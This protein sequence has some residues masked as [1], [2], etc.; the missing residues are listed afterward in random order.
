MQNFDDK[1]FTLLQDDG[2]LSYTELA[3]RSGLPRAAVTSRVDALIASGVLRVVAAPHP[4]FVGL[5]AIA[6]VSIQTSGSSE[7]LV[8]E[9]QSWPSV[10]LVLA[11]GGVHDLVVE[12]RLPNQQELYAVVAAISE[13]PAVSNVSTLIYV[14]VLKGIFMPRHALAPDIK[15]DQVD[16]QLMR[17]L[18]DDGRMSYRDLASRLELSPSAVRQRVL[19][20]LENHVIRIGATLNRSHQTRTVAS[21]VGLSM[22]GDGAALMRELATWPSVEFL[23]RTI[24]RFD[25]VAT[26]AAES[27]AHLR[28]LIEK[29]RSCEGVR[30]TETWVH[31]EAFKERYEWPKPAVQTS[32]LESTRS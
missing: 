29:I 16:V 23:A 5:T 12:A 13:L 15:V 31:L 32:G 27:T 8:Q 28:S 3:T 30:K 10:V 1:I 21:G 24:G 14:D 11:V 9:L 7:R 20:L 18:Q 4:D 19:Y 2:R 17:Q 25:A 6:H 22:R 26:V